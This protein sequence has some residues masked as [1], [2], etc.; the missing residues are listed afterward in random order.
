[1]EEARA[2]QLD[3]RSFCESHTEPGHEAQG[4]ADFDLDKSVS[5]RGDLKEFVVI[6]HSTHGCYL[7]RNNE[8]IPDVPYVPLF[9]QLEELDKEA[10]SAVHVGDSSESTLVDGRKLVCGGP[11]SEL[12]R[13]HVSTWHDTC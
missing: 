10:A 4:Q 1:M 3:S 13:Y 12:G 2:K 5:T 9:E 7:L 6:Y 11:A 8:I